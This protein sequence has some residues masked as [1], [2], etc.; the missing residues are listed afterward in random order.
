MKHITFMQ[1]FYFVS[2]RSG[3]EILIVL[4]TC[5]PL[6]SIEITSEPYLRC[7]DKAKNHMMY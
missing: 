6:P 3:I 4:I 7:K 1:I 5:R 2:T